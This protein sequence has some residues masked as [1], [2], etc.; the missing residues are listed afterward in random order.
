MVFTSNSKYYH[1]C[2]EE[3]IYWGKQAAIYNFVGIGITF[4]GV[5]C[6]C[7]CVKRLDSSKITLV[8]RFVNS[9]YSIV[10]F[11][12]MVNKYQPK[13]NKC[14]QFGSLYLAY[15]ILNGIGIG[16]LVLALLCLCCAQMIK[17]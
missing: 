4:L 11:S 12:Y 7:F 2:P 8:M 16:I 15:I 1:I 17:N 10:I 5:F 14:G 3:M 9:I 6:L 13:N